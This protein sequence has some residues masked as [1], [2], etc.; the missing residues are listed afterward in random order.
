MYVADTGTQLVAKPLTLPIPGRKFVLMRSGKAFR[1]F[2]IYSQRFVHV[3]ATGLLT[4]TGNFTDDS[5]VF[6]FEEL[7]P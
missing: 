1:I 5:S 6:R 7:Q 2:C 4:T 3:D